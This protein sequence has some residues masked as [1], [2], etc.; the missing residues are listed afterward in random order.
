MASGILM[1]FRRA[2]LHMLRI[3]LYS[4]FGGV[5]GLSHFVGLFVPPGSVSLLSFGIGI[6]VRVMDWVRVGLVLCLI[7]LLFFPLSF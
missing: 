5:V 3:L 6:G 1:R 2:P 4:A 7:Y